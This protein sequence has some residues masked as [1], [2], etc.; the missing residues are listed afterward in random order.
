MNAANQP[1]SGATSYD[2]SLRWSLA[3]SATTHSP[4]IFHGDAVDLDDLGHQQFDQ[5]AIGQTDGQFVDRQPTAPFEDVDAHH[6]AAK[7]SD[8]ACDLPEC[9]RAIGE[10][11]S[12][13]V[14][15]HGGVSPAW[16]DPS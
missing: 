16:A 14:R 1:T 6:V 8:A 13:H 15:F 5:A 12:N 7:R 4:H 11:D 9:A 10:P 2:T 3:S